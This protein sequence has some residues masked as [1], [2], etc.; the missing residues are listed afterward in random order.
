MWGESPLL[1]G[2]PWD[3]GRKMFCPPPWAGSTGRGRRRQ[4]NCQEMFQLPWGTQVLLVAP[5]PTSAL[6]F[7][8]RECLNEKTYPLQQAASDVMAS[9][10]AG[11]ESIIIFSQ[12]TSTSNPESCAFMAHITETRGGPSLLEPCGLC[13]AQRTEMWVRALSDQKTRSPKSLADYL[14]SRIWLNT[15]MLYHK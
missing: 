8:T 1:G 15:V 14:N 11:S 4:R 13:A 12:T 6:V 9:Q 10:T 5:S 3:A 7:L 2:S